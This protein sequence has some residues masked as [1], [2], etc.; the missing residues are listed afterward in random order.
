[1]FKGIAHVYTHRHTHAARITFP[2]PFPYFLGMKPRVLHML[3]K[4]SNT[5]YNPKGPMG[6]IYNDLQ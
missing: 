5:V 6:L 4:W 2:S 1:M 3:A